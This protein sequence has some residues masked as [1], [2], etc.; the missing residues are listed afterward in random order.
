[1]PTDVENLIS[2]RRVE[3]PDA[4]ARFHSLVQSPLR[5]AILRYLCDRP[6]E[7][8]E[9]E[10]LM[11]LFRSCSIDVV[12]TLSVFCS[13]CTGTNRLANQLLGHQSIIAWPQPASSSA[14]LR[15]A[16]LSLYASPSK[17]HWRC[18]STP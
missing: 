7:S 17:S 6:D 5:A 1:M 18:R 15:R 9:L 4:E 12:F 8:F 14:A 10:A 16:K 13:S 2:G 11:Q 3:G